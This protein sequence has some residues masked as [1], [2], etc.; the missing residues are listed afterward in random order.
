MLPTIFLL[1]ASSICIADS[2][3]MP[4]QQ[5]N[6]EEY[7]AGITSLDA[8]SGNSCAY[9]KSKAPETRQHGEIIQIF[10]I[11]ANWLGQRIK[12]TAYLKAIN[13]E[14]AAGLYVMTNNNMGKANYDDV[15]IK[16]NRKWTQYSVF[17]DIQ[18]NVI[19]IKFGAW[20]SGAGEILVDNF[21]IEATDKSVEGKNKYIETSNKYFTN[22]DFE[23]ESENNS[24][25]IPWDQ[26]NMEKYE[27]GMISSDSYSGD[28]SAYIKS[29]HTD[30]STFGCIL[31]EI[32][33]PREWLGKQ[34]QL[35][36]YLKSIN[37]KAAFFYFK[38]RYKNGDYSQD[39]MLDRRVKGNTDWTQYALTLDVPYDS[40]LV[41]IGACLMG[42]GEIRIDDFHL[43]VI[44]N[45]IE[46][47]GEY[48]KRIYGSPQNLDFEGE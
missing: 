27:T 29:K 46:T 3:Q 24:L 41:L 10:N 47:T 30:N 16:K 20:L 4:W 34:I 14:D 21:S 7:E 36:G 15:E 32:A 13:V 23:N 26:V 35:T 22:L 28:N 1:V 33:V 2:L 40:V 18:R 17:L 9:I 12:L 25:Q 43:Q 48:H 44:D 42:E 39:E 37:V 31:Q 11:P 45:K 5:Y 38:V 8:F 6:L 19:A